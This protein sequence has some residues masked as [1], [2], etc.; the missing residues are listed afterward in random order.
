[1]LLKEHICDWV[2]TNCRHLLRLLCNCR[3]GRLR[4]CGIGCRGV[5]IVARNG[6][7]CIIGSF[8]SCGCAAISIG[9]VVLAVSAIIVTIVA[10]VAK[11]AAAA[12]AIIVAIIA[13]CTAVA[14]IHA[15]IAGTSAHRVAIVV[16]MVAPSVAIKTDTLNIFRRQARG[17]PATYLPRRVD[18]TPNVSVF[19]LRS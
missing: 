6:T 1:M 12:H 9:Y 19:N 16:V 17:N 13:R 2:L 4:C 15:T 14:R 8:Q 7:S 18:E 5:C 11:V 10:A 3:C